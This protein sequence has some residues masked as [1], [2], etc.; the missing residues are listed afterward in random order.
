MQ[1]AA[2]KA[3]AEL[4][5]EPVPDEVTKVYNVSKLEFGREYLIPKPVDPRLI[6]KVAPAVAKAAIETGVART[7]ITDWDEYNEYLKNL[8][9]TIK[10]PKEL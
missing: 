6:Y 3:L 10:C 8:M 9:S 7:P 1:V 4:A 5:K 2:A